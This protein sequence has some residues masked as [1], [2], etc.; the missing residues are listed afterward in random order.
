MTIYTYEKAEQPNLDTYNDAIIISDI[1]SAYLYLSWSAHDCILRVIFS[2][3]L[4][5]EEK[6]TLDWIIV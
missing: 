1:A 4:T 3:E 5:T 2:R 6:A